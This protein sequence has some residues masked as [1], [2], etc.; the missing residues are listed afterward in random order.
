VNARDLA[1][2]IGAPI[3]LV[4]VVGGAWFT[5]AGL[6]AAFVAWPAL[7]VLAVAAVFMARAATVQ[8]PLG[9]SFNHEGQSC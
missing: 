1:V 6:V 8:R 9:G 7:N 5:V 4:A 2:L 3:A